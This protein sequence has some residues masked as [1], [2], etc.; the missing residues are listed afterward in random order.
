MEAF[1]HGSSDGK[2]TQQGRDSGVAHI[3]VV[4]HSEDGEAARGRRVRSEE[5]AERMYAT[6]AQVG[7]R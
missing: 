7:A 2:A 1:E 4:V 3:R 6:G 5:G